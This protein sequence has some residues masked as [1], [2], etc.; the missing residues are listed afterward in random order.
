[1]KHPAPIRDITNDN[2]RAQNFLLTREEARAFLSSRSH[3]GRV[4]FY[5]AI[6]GDAPIVD[7]EGKETGKVF[8]YGLSGSV[9]LSAPAALKL[10]AELL[11]MSAEQRGGRLPVARYYWQIRP[12]AKRPDVAI[13]I[14]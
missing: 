5:A 6:S 14:G 1:M 2:R 9:Q 8:P 4:T 3:G 7:T 12:G 11:P 10:A 13:Y